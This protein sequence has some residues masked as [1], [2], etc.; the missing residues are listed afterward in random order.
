MADVM[1]GAKNKMQEVGNSAAQAATGAAEGVRNAANYVTDQAKQA[2]TNASKS[3]A[4]VGSY[5]E[6]KAE[7]ATSSLAGGLRAAGDAIRQNAPHEGRLG[8]ASSA[9]AQSLEDTSNYLEREGLQGIG[10]DLSSL[11]KRNPIPALLLGIGLGFL[12]ARAT[13]TRT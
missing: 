8:Q 3:A 5:V 6:N 4:N 11:I 9:V 10:K 13:T 7:E 1:T 2:A 12:V